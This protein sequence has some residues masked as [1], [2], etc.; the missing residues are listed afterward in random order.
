[1]ASVRTADEIGADLR[2]LKEEIKTVKE[3]ISNPLSDADRVQDKIRLNHLYDKEKKLETERSYPLGS[4]RPVSPS[5]HFPVSF[6]RLW[7][8]SLLLGVQWSVR[9]ETLL[10]RLAWMWTR[11]PKH[12]VGG[13]LVMLLLI[14]WWWRVGTSQLQSSSIAAAFHDDHCVIPCFSVFRRVSAD[15]K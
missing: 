11:K 8:G 3:S 2:A 4:S 15:E 10:G 12:L 9:R 7:C 6:L 1:M 13:S 14:A 5:F